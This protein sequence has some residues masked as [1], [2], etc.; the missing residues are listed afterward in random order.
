MVSTGNV[1][2]G[3]WFN[4]VTQRST[5]WIQAGAFARY[6]GMGYSN[7]FWTTFK[8]NVRAGDFIGFD[9][10]GD[11]VVDHIGYVTAKSGGSIKIAQHSTD[12]HC[13][14]EILVG[15]RAFLA[16]ESFIGLGGRCG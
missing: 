9:S 16:V 8:N 14:M 5:S 13:G 6:M 3:W 11:G 1:N 15:R 7:S 2:S 4:S 10:G 12:Y